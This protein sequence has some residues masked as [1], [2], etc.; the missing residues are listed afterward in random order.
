MAHEYL[1][2]YELLQEQ[3]DK[4]AEELS[5]RHE[6][7][8]EAV[9]RA[10]AECK[11]N[12]LEATAEL[13]K[14][15]E[16][17]IELITTEAKNDKSSYALLHTR[18]Q[19]EVNELKAALELARAQPRMDETRLQILINEHRNLLNRRVDEAF[20]RAGDEWA[21]QAAELHVL[22]ADA[23][24]RRKE[25]RG[26]FKMDEAS[27]QNLR[28]DLTEDYLSLVKSHTAAI[29]QLLEDFNDDQMV[30][31]LEA[32]A[33]KQANLA[34]PTSPPSATEQTVV[35][36]SEGLTT[37]AQEV[38][39]TTANAERAAPTEP[40][41]EVSTSTPPM[42]ITVAPATDAP[43]ETATPTQDRPDHPTTAPDPE[44]ILDILIEDCDED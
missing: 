39:T 42:N 27:V 8:T 34:T 30:F 18:L 7:E 14:H 23:E 15:Y 40:A 4:L 29:E 20:Q 22:R 35:L 11:K 28:D 9:E 5:S 32:E 24:N 2:K 37:T 21:A 33:L 43:T 1:A 17:S 41:P 6:K 12:F 31:R 19:D 13:T 36:P 44:T 10:R 3:H 25:G 26:F 38:T 16:Q